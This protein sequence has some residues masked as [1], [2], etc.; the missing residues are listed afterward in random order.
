MRDR[1]D[2]LIIIPAYNEEKNIGR[3]IESIKKHIDQTIDIAVIDDASRDLTYQRAEE[4][5]VI[6]I[7][8][9]FNLGYG[10]ALLTGYKFALENGYEYLLQ[11]DAD[12]QHEPA[13]IKELL[14]PVKDKKADVVIGSR[15][16]EKTQYSPGVLRGIGVKLFRF[17]IL[18]LTNKKITDPTSGYQAMNKRVFKFFTQYNYPADYPDADIIVLLL[19]S[20]FNIVEIPMRMYQNYEK[21]MHNG[22]RPVYYFFKMLLCIFIVCIQRKEK[23]SDGHPS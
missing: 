12:G 18:M 1:A 11:L 5:D 7:R 22:L 2:T 21:S 17:L 19:F 10:G 14:L 8:H 4:H 15:Y 23:I 16:L 6:V 20:G 13:Y 3:V 9:P